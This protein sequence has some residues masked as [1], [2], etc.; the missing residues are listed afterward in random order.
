[1]ESL[2]GQDILCFGPTDWWH[3]NPSCTSHIMQRLAEWNR[4]LYINPFSADLPAGISRG[5]GRRVWRKLRSTLVCFRKVRDRLYT[6]SPVFVPRHGRPTI[7]R[8]NNALLQAQIRSVCR[9]LSMR[10]TIVWFENPRAADALDW[11]TGALKVYHVSDLF[12]ACRYTRDR[13]TLEKREAR[14]T[15]E[16]DALIC[17][18]HALEQAKRRMRDGDVHYLPHGVDFPRFHAAGEARP[19]YPELADLPRPIAGYYGTL[20]ASNDI[21]LLQYC[22]ESAPD[23]S[24]V[25]GG[26][27]TQGDYSGLQSLPNVR[28]LG[29]VPYERVPA[30]A[31]NFDV[32]L[33]PWKLSE[34]IRHCSPLKFYEYLASGRPIVSVPIPQV[35]AD[36]ERLVGVAE[37][38]ADFLV[39][40]RRELAEDNDTRR[41]AR[42][43]LAERHDWERQ[44]EQLSALLAARRAA[45][46]GTS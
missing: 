36:A 46:A 44:L 18:S 6:F 29:Q 19:P 12:T 13:K 20:T 43:D 10:P 11:Y 22:A 40:I 17:V 35:L 27:I 39:A 25:L 16:S 32:C 30:L 37:T 26:T 42:I 7:D 14:L 38:P 45:G 15:M 4:V 34:W 24:F 9:L 8:I 41:D 23:I 31:A 28:F 5:L 2:R 21:E 1:M 3:R 33:L